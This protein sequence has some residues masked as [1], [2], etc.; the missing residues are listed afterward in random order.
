MLRSAAVGDDV[1]FQTAEVPV[2]VVLVVAVVRDNDDINTLRLPLAA[3][4]PLGVAKVVQGIAKVVVEA[5]VVVVVVVVDA[6]E[7]NV[8]D[9]AGAL[10]NVSETLR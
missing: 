3:L 10:I 8:A 1:E 5:V 9:D 6:V 4:A 2:V 7:W